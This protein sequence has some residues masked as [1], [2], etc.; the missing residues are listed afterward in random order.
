METEIT[1][2]RHINARRFEFLPEHDAYMRQYYP[3]TTNAEIAA[4]LGV[5]KK[6]LTNYAR[7]LGV[8]KDAEWLL[9]IQKIDCIRK[10]NEGTQQRIKG[11]KPKSERFLAYIERKKA[12]GFPNRY[13]VPKGHCTKTIVGEEKWKEQC[14]KNSKTMKE[15][16]LM[17][18]MRY[19]AGLEQ[20]TKYRIGSSPR[21]VHALRYRLRERGYV[22]QHGG[23]VCYYTP[24]T[25]RDVKVESGR[26][27]S[28]FSFKPITEY[29]DQRA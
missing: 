11:L 28:P 4:V 24:T 3:T 16:R 10:A 1:K 17:E 8:R 9:Q 27:K 25:Q 13:K 21:W 29:N 22:I 5:S 19:M 15:L 6:C 2:V 12:E 7:R 20:K 23:Y 26:R 18:K 14:K